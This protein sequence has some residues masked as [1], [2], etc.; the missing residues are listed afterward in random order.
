[1]IVICIPCTSISTFAG[2][3]FEKDAKKKDTWDYFKNGKTIIVVSSITKETC[4]VNDMQFAPQP[5]YAS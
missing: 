1:M 3:V 5:L 2:G 4:E